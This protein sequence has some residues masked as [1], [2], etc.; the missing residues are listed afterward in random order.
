MSEPGKSKRKNVQKLNANMGHGVCG[1]EQEIHILR[2][3]SVNSFRRVGTSEGVT[4]VLGL[5]C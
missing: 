3:K 5:I 2:R 4:R 1:M